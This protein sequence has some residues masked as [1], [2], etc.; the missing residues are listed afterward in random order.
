MSTSASA[1]RPLVGRLLREPLIHFLVA[2]LLLFAGYR[3]LR[4]DAGLREDS[5]RIVITSDDIDQ[6]QV[7]WTAQWRRPPTPDE[8]RGLVQDKIREEMLYREALAL[9]LDK[10][11]TI[12]KR[13]LAQK[14]EFLADDSSSLGEPT[15]DEL[16]AWFEKNGQRFAL[17]SLVTF[18]HLFFSFDRRGEDARSDAAATLIKLSGSSANP[19]DAE[20]IADPFMF[21]DFYA[22]RTSDQIANI[23]GTA[24][25]QSMLDLKP[26][27]W[28]GPIGSGFGWHL[29]LVESITPDRIPAFEEVESLVKSDWVAEQRA[30]SKGKMLEAIGARYHVVLP[31]TSP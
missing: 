16:K 6:L 14:M 12:V 13:R 9:G 18:R 3:V 8:M 24:F 2:A 1:Q 20:K 11:D 7:A 30:D 19:S 21:Q 17:H 23:F 15:T 28:R 4:P 5:N 10:D 27:A 31:N 25:A 29:V 26:G 22:E